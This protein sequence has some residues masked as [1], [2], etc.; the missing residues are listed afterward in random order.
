MVINGRQW[1]RRIATA[2]GVAACIALFATAPVLAKMPYFSVEITPLEPV[3][4]DPVLITVRTWQDPAHTVPEPFDA[5]DLNGLLVLRSTNDGTPSIGIA[6]D[7]DAP[8]RFEGTVTLPTA[9][10][11][12]LVAFPDR[13]G[14][15]SPEV[16][17]GYPDTILLTVRP[18]TDLT[19]ALLLIS[20]IAAAIG[21]AGLGVLAVR[22]RR[23][24][25]HAVH[26]SIVSMALIFAI[27]ACNEAASEP[28]P[29]LTAS[30]RASSPSASPLTLADAADC[31]VTVPTTAPPEIGDRLFGSGSAYG[32]GDLWVGGLWP[33][34][35][36][37]VHWSSSFVAVDGSI[38]MKF[39]WWRNVSGELEITGRRLDGSAPP[40]HAGVPD[41]YGETGFQASGV[42]F[43][44]EGCWEVTGRVGSSRLTF[45]TL[46][47]KEDDP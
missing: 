15:S 45:V 27:T 34:G 38:G 3:A 31:P 1:A 36:I 47:I 10:E 13:S 28:D 16:P 35:I 24:R 12:T 4:G 33:D 9:G 42:S 2:M 23:L 11:W 7:A 14:W 21:L 46:V 40:L 25:R 44:A 32:N 18:E 37:A 30:P 5:P 8:G 22:S 26:R 6:L 17:R 20:G 39:G 43:P 29:V 19:R 41:G